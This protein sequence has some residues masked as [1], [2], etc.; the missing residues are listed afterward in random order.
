VSDQ[1]ARDKYEGWGG[2]AVHRDYVKSMPAVLETL[3]FVTLGGWLVF[4]ILLLRAY[5]VQAKR[6]VPGIW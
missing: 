1:L 6:L 2:F 5:S 4:E 3:I